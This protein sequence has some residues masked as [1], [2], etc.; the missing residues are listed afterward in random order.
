MSKLYKKYLSLKT[1]YPDD[2]LL[3][4]NGLFYIFLEKDAKLVSEKIGLKL[5]YL[6]SE[7]QKCGF[8]KDTLPKYSELLE[9]NHLNFKIIENDFTV[10]ESSPDYIHNSQ[11]KK[12]MD[13]I[14]SLDINDISPLKALGILSDM[15]EELRYL[16]DE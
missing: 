15:K 1:N 2:M 9:K 3:F 6:N 5:T 4:N 11:I 7:V 14:Q 12:I 16:K 13:L 10:V 8:P